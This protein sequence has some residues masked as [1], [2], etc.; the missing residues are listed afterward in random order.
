MEIEK[1]IILVTGA[2]QGIGLQIAHALVRE[3]AI[4][5]FAARSIDKLRREAE[6]A[7]S[8]AIAVKM[9][10]TDDLSVETAI[11][12]IIARYGRIDAVI[13]NA[14]INGTL[15]LWSD[16]TSF[17]TR[18]IFDSH[19]L[20][21]E[22]VMRAVLPVMKKQKSGV[23][24]NI[25]SIVGWV[26]M[27]GLS[28]YSAAKDAVISISRT[29]REEL[30]YFGIDVRIFTPAH[31]NTGH[32]LERKTNE[33]PESVAEELVKSLLQDRPVTVMEG[34]LILLNRFFPKITSKMM[35]QTGFKALAALRAKSEKIELGL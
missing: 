27:P 23:I 19:V 1:S 15:S 13:N 11:N 17:Q 20:G 35:N 8:N 9:D 26:P 33:T 30:K 28:V 24:V 10:V 6:K 7:G 4:V 2:S 5:V 32:P 21:T 31:T 29:L 12:E 14:G 18:E 22:R 16:T 3:G 25:A 34:S